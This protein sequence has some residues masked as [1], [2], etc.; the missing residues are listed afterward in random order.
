MRWT[1][2]IVLSKHIS[3]YKQHG[4]EAERSSALNNG[5][6]ANLTFPEKWAQVFWKPAWESAEGV[7]NS[8]HSLRLIEKNARE[9]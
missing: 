1:P 6:K 4:Y 7:G 8:P 5:Q 9:T 3:L 2:T